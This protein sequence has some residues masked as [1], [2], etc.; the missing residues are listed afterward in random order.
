MEGS[1]VSKISLTIEGE[2]WADVGLQLVAMYESLNRSGA[3][4]LTVVPPETP[5]A[6]PQPIQTPP[7]Q[8]GA[9]EAVSGPEGQCPKHL[10]PWK[11]GQFGKF[12]SSKDDTQ[13][14]GYCSLRPGDIWNG[15]R[16]AA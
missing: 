3:A 16:A 13:P 1:R 7:V 12:C 2:D 15:K 14:K 5:A 9:T 11:D 10:R 4:A 6:A 8:N